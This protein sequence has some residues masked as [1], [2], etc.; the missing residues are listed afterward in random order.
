MQLFLKNVCRKFIKFSVTQKLL[1]TINNNF[2]PL[3]LE[4]IKKHI[5]INRPK[6]LYF[7]KVALHNLRKPLLIIHN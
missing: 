6:A 1:L 2:N 4:G 5:S 7:K 3:E